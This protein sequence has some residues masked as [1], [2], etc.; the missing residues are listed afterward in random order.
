MERSIY[1]L[2]PE[3]ADKGGVVKVRIKNAGL[4]IVEERKIVLTRQMLTTLYRRLTLDEEHRPLW[5]EIL[6]QLL[7][8]EVTVGLVQGPCAVKK[9]YD[10]CGD[11]TK[12][13]KCSPFSLRFQFAGRA[14]PIQCGRY[15]YW[16]NGIHRSKTHDEVKRDIKLFFAE[17]ALF[18][19]A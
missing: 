18:E 7:G 19:R 2:K 17:M 4:E 12:P 5:E 1:F 6:R 10:L 3:F 14:T 9:L 8:K 13:N 16:A 15:Q 11:S